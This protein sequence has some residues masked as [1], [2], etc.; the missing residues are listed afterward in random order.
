MNMEVLIQQAKE[1]ALKWGPSVIAAIVTLVLGWIIAGILTG[2]ARRI[3][4]RAKLE[5]T[6]VGFSC[7]II[8]TGLLA[9]VV[10]TAIQKLGVPTTSFVAVIG[11]AGLAVGFALQGSLANF[12]AG[13]MLIIFRP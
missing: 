9:L 1:L 4:R 2:M 8:K 3:M 12:A 13:V 11:A 7:N 6:L 5:E 10:I